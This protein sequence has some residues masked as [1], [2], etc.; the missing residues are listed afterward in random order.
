MTYA[1]ARV[2]LVCS[3]PYHQ[4]PLE[5]LHQLFLMIQ[6]QTAPANWNS[7]YDRRCAELRQKQ[8]ELTSQLP[9][10]AAGLTATAQQHL[11]PFG[12]WSGEEKAADYGKYHAAEDYGDEE[13]QPRQLAV[14]PTTFGYNRG[15]SEYKSKYIEWPM[16]E[17]KVCKLH[18]LCL[19]CISPSL[20]NLAPAI[21]NDVKF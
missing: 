6:Q 20:S 19:Q 8:S 7:E 12:A 16:Q 2:L 3:V 15:T 5:Q 21:I 17:T 4:S 9:A 14:R 18:P 11:E 13:P 10:P 1:L